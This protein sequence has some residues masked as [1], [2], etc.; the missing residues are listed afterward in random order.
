MDQLSSANRQSAS[1][2]NAGQLA[3]GAK[4]DAETQSYPA[5]FSFAISGHSQSGKQKNT[6]P[7]Q[8]KVVDNQNKLVRA[9][10]PVSDIPLPAT[11]NS[12]PYTVPQTVTALL[13][14]SP[15]GQQPIS[16]GA[17]YDAVSARNRQ[18][19]SLP[20]E[21]I[22]DRAHI[23]ANTFGGTGS[24]P[25]IVATTAHFNRNQMWTD[26][27]RPLNNARNAHGYRAF[28]YHV[29]VDYNLHPWRNGMIMAETF[30]PTA[31]NFDIDEMQYQPNTESTNWANWQRTGTTNAKG[32]IVNYSANIAHTPNFAAFSQ[33]VLTAQ[34]NYN[35]LNN[36]SDAQRLIWYTNNRRAMTA[37]ERETFEEN[38]DNGYIGA[39]ISPNLNSIVQRYNILAGVYFNQLTIAAN[40]PLISEARARALQIVGFCRVLREKL[41]DSATI[42]GQVTAIET[43]AQNLADQIQAYLTTPANYNGATLNQLVVAIETAIAAGPLSLNQP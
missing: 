40:R 26:T 39:Y 41:P 3:G 7:I 37:G 33:N 34:P 25:N 1:V 38:M 12:G 11:V 4:G 21:S 23:V 15:D 27:E 19:L 43:A 32:P 30:L 8:R 9:D 42:R 10:L 28:R 31:F 36:M 5:K 18:G 13:G 35:A 2:S 16:G 20:D 24:P 29:N 14:N 17:L 6:A 22:Y